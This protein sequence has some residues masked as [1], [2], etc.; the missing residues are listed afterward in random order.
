MARVAAKLGN[1]HPSGVNPV[2]LIGGEFT[3]TPDAL[4]A[5]VLVESTDKHDVSVHVE[6][7][8]ACQGMGCA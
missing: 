1:I 4:V 2:R 3:S 6:L 8:S 7:C 5:I